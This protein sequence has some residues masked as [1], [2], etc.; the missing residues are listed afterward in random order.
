MQMIFNVKHDLRRKTR[1]VVGGHVIDSTGHMTYSSTIKDLSVRLM[2]LIAMKHDLGFMAGNIGNVFCT[3]PCAEKIW[4]VAGDQFGN[5]KGSTVVLKRALYGLKTAL[6]SFHQFLGDFLR[7]MG[8]VPSRSDQDLWLQ[9][10]RNMQDM[11][12]LQHTLMILSSLP[13]IHQNT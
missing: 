2:L 5:K 13:R 1:F 4:S 11:T 6:A 3:A 7:V 8:F 9:S 12:V 10:Q